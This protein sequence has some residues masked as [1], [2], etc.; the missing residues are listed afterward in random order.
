MQNYKKVV[1]DLDQAVSSQ[2]KELAEK[3]ALLAVYRGGWSIAISCTCLVVLKLDILLILL[4][5]PPC[6]CRLAE[7]LEGERKGH[8]ILVKELC[9]QLQQALTDDSQLK[10]KLKDEH[11]AAMMQKQKELS[12][13]CQEA[14][15]ANQ[16]LDGYRSIIN[17]LHAALLGRC[18]SQILYFYLTLCEFAAMQIHLAI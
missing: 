18:S 12:D 9:S 16:Q 3:T 8:D 4:L 1:E 6:R 10:Q 14:A 17:Y 11:Q 15:V 13:V 5:F 2:E 7:T